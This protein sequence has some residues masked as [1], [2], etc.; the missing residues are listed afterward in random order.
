MKKVIGF[1]LV[2][3]FVTASVN[4]QQ[5]QKSLSI[6][7]ALEI[8]LQV[9]YALCHLHAHGIVHRDLKPENILITDTGEIKVID[10][11]IAQLVDEEKN[12]ETNEYKKIIQKHA[13]AQLLKWT[14]TDYSGKLIKNFLQNSH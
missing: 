3:L 1:V 4:A 9:G 13:S 11:G 6:K 8:I 14:A 10:F 2:A 5:K 7:K 12:K